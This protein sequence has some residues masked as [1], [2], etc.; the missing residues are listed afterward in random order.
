MQ[1]TAWNFGGT[2][3]IATLLLFSQ[4]IVADDEL[5]GGVCSDNMVLASSGAR[6]WGSNGKSGAIV[7]VEIDNK[8]AA[9][10]RVTADG[11][12]SVDLPVHAASTNHTIKVTVGSATPK[13][14]NNV[15]FG[16]VIL[17]GGQVCIS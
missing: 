1:R 12:W 13:I 7:D 11:S 3:F 4:Q 8:R 14:L 6:I 15:A 5:C 17:C 9:V 16:F 10:G 2:C